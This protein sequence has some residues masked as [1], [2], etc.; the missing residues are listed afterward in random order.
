[1]KNIILENNRGGSTPIVWDD[2]IIL[3]SGIGEGSEGEDGV[4]CFDW[5]GNLLWQ[6][7]LGTQKFG[8]SNYALK[9]GAVTVL[10]RA[11]VDAKTCCFNNAL[12]FLSSHSRELLHHNQMFLFLRV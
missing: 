8:Y 6:V 9:S 1:M 5:E 10:V 12:I 4:L 7:K 11:T 3:T 2:R